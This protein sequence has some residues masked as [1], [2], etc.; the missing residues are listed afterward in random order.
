MNDEHEDLLQR[1]S[2]GDLEASDPRV[3]AAF[4]A[5]PSLRDRYE[6]LLAAERELVALGQLAAD[7]EA[8]GAAGPAAVASV[9]ALLG[10][11]RTAPRTWWPWTAAVA[12]AVLL[13]CWLAWPRREAPGDGVLGGGA[14][15]VEQV[16]GV[17]RVHID[18][19]L[20]PGE[21]YHLRLVAGGGTA[22]TATSE[23]A[24]WVFPAAW[25]DALAAATTAELVVEC[26]DGS[27]LFVVRKVVLK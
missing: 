14:V 26:H 12:A 16:D 17:V 3:R 4:A 15:K 19:P 9:R 11:R 1:L 25:M 10:G 23:A 24:D 18:D 6:Q 5:D 8:V 13:A 2:C 27:G 20:P 22:F 21:Q 7:R